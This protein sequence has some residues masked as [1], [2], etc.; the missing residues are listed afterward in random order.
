MFNIIIIHGN[1][2]NLPKDHQ[3]SSL[4]HIQGIRIYIFTNGSFKNIYGNF[5]YNG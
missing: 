2:T 4:V 5:I 1:A 3:F